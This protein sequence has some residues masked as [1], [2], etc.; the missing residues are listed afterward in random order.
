MRSMG[1]RRDIRLILHVFAAAF[2]VYYERP[3]GSAGEAVKV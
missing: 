1:G 3:P 2:L